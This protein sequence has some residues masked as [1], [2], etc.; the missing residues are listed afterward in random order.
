MANRRITT[1]LVVKASDQ[2][3]AKI[4]AMSG[5]TGRF[6]DKVRSDMAGLQKLRGPLRLIQDYKALQ[7]TFGKSEA[8][9]RR[10]RERVAEL[11]R[12]M[13]ATENP[14]KGMVRG[15]E[16]A[17]RA[18]E[19][20]RLAH[21][22]NGTALTGLRSKLRLAGVNT[23]D[24]AGEQ[25]RLTTALGT[26]NAAFAQQ[27]RRMERLQTM[28]NR[29]AAGR[30]R[31]DRSLATAANLSFAGNA[32]AGVGRRILHS[33]TEIS[34]KSGNQQE[35]FTEFQNLT[36]ADDDRISRLR[37]ELSGLRDV[38]KQSVDEMLEALGVLVGKGMD[39][40]DALGALPSTARAAFATDTGSDEMGAAGFALYDNLNVAPGQL[41]KAY[42]IMAK[43]GKEGGFEL[44]AMARKFP[45][46]TAGARALKMEGLDAVA[47][48]TAA[49]QIAMKSAGS[50]DQA[51][52]NLSNFLGK[53]TS[54]ETVRRFAKAGVSI[55]KE[56][57]NALAN[58]VSPME[59]MMGIISDL[60]GGDAL[61]MG[62]LFGDKQVLDFLR[63]MIPN[64]EEY[65]RIRDAAFGAEGVVD[66]DLDRRMRDFNVQKGQLKESLGDLFTLSPDTLDTLTKMME[67]ADAFVE[68]LIVWKAENPEFAKGLFLGATALG[69]M[70]VGAGALMIAGAGLIGTMAV[71]RFGL[72]GFGA[73]AAFAGGDL[74]G[75]TRRVRGLS[76]TRLQLR[77]PNFRPHVGDFRKFGT[78]A[79]AEM[80]DL[81]RRHNRTLDRMARKRRAARIAAA[82]GV[83]RFALRGGAIGTG[84]YFGLG[85]KPVENGTITKDAA[86]TADYG[87]G[88]I[89]NMQKTDVRLS[90]AAATLREFQGVELPTKARIAKLREDAA[91][92]RLEIEAAQAALAESPEFSSGITNPNRVLAQADL[93]AAQASLRATED[94]LANAKQASL[95]I[96]G[97]LMVV[98][99]TSVAPE[100]DTT[101]VDDALR[102][103]SQLSAQ[104][105]SMPSAT[106][107]AT[108]P[109]PAGARRTGGPVQAGLPYEVNEDTPR[110]EWFVPSASGGILN[111]SQAQSVFRSHLKPPPGADGRL[112]RSAQRVRSA[113]RA[114]MF[115]SPVLGASVLSA[116]AATTASSADAKSGGKR[117]NVTVQITGPITIPVPS[118]V[119]NPEMI[120]ELAADLLGQRVEA[121]FDA[122][123]SD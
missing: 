77:R 113:G 122:S 100:I 68:K 86:N 111:V 27:A 107:N 16:R 8:A 3:S 14:T 112:A 84:L 123:L 71:M 51:A 30:E 47:E 56:L 93:T 117:G 45:E 74:L 114:A 46:I 59:H 120:A 92:Y 42:D 80:L 102:K 29:L 12:E 25:L 23:G 34:D 94:Q 79:M 52:T 119:T 121:I 96:Q 53:L 49:L 97:A 95:E 118:D 40:E 11:R 31:L 61:K 105:R 85:I 87:Q 64:M 4:R 50:E 26:A 82:K 65:G 101:S 33:S 63:A 20:L 22:K 110:S 106:V 115:A 10:A 90:A 75:L 109:K 108:A 43:G 32:T 37:S 38:T 21:D 99:D 58:G 104:L 24:L 60:T 57:E 98:N 83:G 17:K 70:A 69:A 76:G 18:A 91:A 36:G 1:E 15:F 88:A 103:V 7:S 54:P 41:E 116:A 81:E 48:L 73:R 5:V 35:A 66:A 67:R 13:R 28:Q 62:E 6:A 89:N 55:E 72:A 2:Y 78:S 39:L 9:L 44:D 19:R